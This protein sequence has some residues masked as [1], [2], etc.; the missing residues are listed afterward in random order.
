MDYFGMAALTNPIASLREPVQVTQ[1]TA[2]IS[3]TQALAELKLLRKRIEH[4]L[5]DTEF[6]T[7]KTKRSNLDTEKFIADA[8]AYYQSYMDLIDR[9]NRLK[10]A[11]VR[12]NATT[13]VR[14][15]GKDYTVAEAVERK[16]SLDM[17]KNLL[18]TMERQYVQTRAAH[19]THSREQD[20]RVERLISTELSKEAKTNIDVVK[21]L[22]DT[23]LADNSAEIIDPLNLED[24]IRALRK[25]I[26]D[27]ET[28]VDWVL[29]E[30]NGK[31][32]ISL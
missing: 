12:S 14:V 7:L 21:Q 31:T 16:R 27:F 3:I 18:M 4:N 19:A 23:F 26:D 17:Y 5:H 11:I 10:S 24:R 22:R 9:Y 25:E 6:M 28:T 13:V 2:P 30:S 32:L 8:K 15:A 20:E 1:S 29:S